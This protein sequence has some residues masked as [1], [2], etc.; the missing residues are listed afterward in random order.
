[1][2]NDYPFLGLPENLANVEVEKD[3]TV[4]LPDGS[5]Y[6]IKGKKHKN[7]GEKTFLPSGTKVFSD[8]LKLPKEM[9]S[10]LVGKTFR[11]QKSPAQLSKQFDTMKYQKM[12]MNKENKWDKLARETAEMMFNKNIAH[13]NSIFEA[14]EDFKDSKQT[15]IFKYGGT[16][17]DKYLKGG[18]TDPPDPYPY[19]LNK[20][21]LEEDDLVTFDF[22]NQTYGPQSKASNPDL[23]GEQGSYNPAHK[24]W[25][26]HYFPGQEFDAKN[27]Q[28]QHGKAYQQF[29][30]QAYDYDDA[31]GITQDNK[32]GNVTAH[33]PLF[34]TTMQGN[35]EGQV[36]L[37]QYLENPNIGKQYGVDLSKAF[38]GKD[39]FNYKVDILADPLPPPAIGNDNTPDMDFDDN[40]NFEEQKIP[41]DLIP[42]DKPVYPSVDTSPTPEDMLYGVQQGMLLTSLATLGKENPYYSKTELKPIYKRFSPINNL[43]QERAFTLMQENIENSNLPEQVKQS[44]RQNMYANMM[45]ATG[46]VDLQNY[47]G[48]LQ[49]DNDNRQI[50][51]TTLNQNVQNRE[52]AN[53][54]YAM[55]K[56]RVDELYQR[57]KMG[58]VNNMM[59]LW[60]GKIEEKSNVGLL[61]QMSRNYKLVNG[62]AV[63][64]QGQGTNIDPNLIKS[65]Y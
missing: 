63:F 23:F 37:E 52:V 4:L 16:Y 48:K 64:D 65:S 22:G 8:Y 59:D 58:Y 19:S 42:Q 10:E 12:M 5:L 15:D 51:Q 43:A 21:V 46:Q 25:F 7:G 30:G 26:N 27:F 34:S 49:T 61:N 11:K 50:L 57:Q 31:K 38:T 9:A 2:K 3:E 60:R 54:Q 40:F 55:D 62:K 14:Q 24:T 17:L 35:K 28:Q 56:G 41:L 13:Q 36:T 32:Y 39:R 53:R 47:Q 44:Q 45:E 29:T 1:M 33:A 20:G 18:E 6:N